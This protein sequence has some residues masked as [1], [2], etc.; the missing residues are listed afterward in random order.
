MNPILDTCINPHALFKD[1]VYY[2][3]QGENSAISIRQS[4]DITNLKE[5]KKQIVWSSSDS[6]SLSSIW[7]PE[8]AYLNNKWYI[9]FAADDGNRAN[10]H[11]YVLENSSKN[12]LEGTFIFKAEIKLDELNNWGDQPT[13]FVHKGTQY[14]AWTSQEGDPAS[15]KYLLSLNLYIA[16]MSN[17]WTLGSKKIL[18][19]RPELEWEREWINEDG[20]RSDVP[21]YCNESPAFAYSQDSTKIIL[22]Y[23]T[24]SYSTIYHCI[25]M[26]YVNSDANLLDPNSWTKYSEPVFKQD[27]NHSIYAPGGACFIPS[28]DLQEWYMLY[29]ARTESLPKYNLEKKTFNSS[30]RLQKVNWD[31]N[32]MPVLGTP[33]NIKKKLKKPSGTK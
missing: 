1:G 9:Y 32:G 16:E 30:L 20:S 21:Y 28:P 17:P 5:S 18:I 23:N 22:F 27:P 31:I 11:L 4:M 14:L 29:H 6:L 7:A 25:G 19:S 3:I 13:T 10:R 2:Y 15:W 26:N 33:D 8:I 24:N 12:P